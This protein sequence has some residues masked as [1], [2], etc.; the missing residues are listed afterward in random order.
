MVI[1]AKEIL[2]HTGEFI[3]REIESAACVTLNDPNWIGINVE[4]VLYAVVRG[5]RVRMIVWPLPHVPGF[6]VRQ[7]RFVR[8]LGGEFADRSGRVDKPV[9]L[10][11]CG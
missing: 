7:W 9:G 2:L 5:V 4:V 3:V 11:H 1:V 8:S 10:N 6:L